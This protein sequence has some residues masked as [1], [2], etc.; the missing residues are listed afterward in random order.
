MRKVYNDMNDSHHLNKHSFLSERKNKYINV[1]YIILFSVLLVLLYL[2]FPKE[3]VNNDV[4]QTEQ[5][6]D[7]PEPIEP[8]EPTEGY[9][10][11]VVNS[12]Y[13]R[14]YASPMTRAA[15]WWAWIR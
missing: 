3:P 6:T 1:I 15:S 13:V 4:P 2:V 10:S 9:E 12:Q 7:I 11:E 8:I 14:L 5:S